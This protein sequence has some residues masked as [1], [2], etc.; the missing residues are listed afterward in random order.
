MKKASFA[1]II[2]LFSLAHV[3]VFA[4]MEV[5]APDHGLIKGRVTDRHII[6]TLDNNIP[7]ATVTV[8]NDLLLGVG[9]RIA[10]TDAA[11]NYEVPNLPPGMYRITVTKRG[12]NA[13]VNNVFVTRGGE[14]FYDVRLLKTVTLMTLFWRT[15]PYSWSLLLCSLLLLVSIPVAAVYIIKRFH[16]LVELGSN[17]GEAFMSR[18]REAMKND[19]ILGVNSICD[20]VGGLANILKAGLLRYAELTKQGEV[21]GEGLQQVIWREK[22]WGAIEKAGVTA[23]REFKFR[24]SLI[25]TMFGSIGGMSLLCGSLGMVVWTNRAYTTLARMGTGDPT[26]LAGG[27]SDGWLIAACGLAIATASA[28]LCL[29]TFIIYEIFK[30]RTNALISRTQQTFVSMVNSLSTIQISGKTDQ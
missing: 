1:L 19:D 5:I 13:S 30:K 28:C 8:A 29:T 27:I 9:P 15:R 10:T 20:E 2:G 7:G 11:G 22:I 16:K 23:K 26:M 6:R 21:A 17:I 4:E 24:W 12:Y 3:C 18:V 14:A 25:A